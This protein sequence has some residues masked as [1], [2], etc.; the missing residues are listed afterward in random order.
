MDMKTLRFL[1]LP[2]LLAVA[3]VVAGC[4]GGGAKS[5]PQN[6]VAVVGADTITKAQYNALIDSARSTYKAKKTAFPKVGTSAYKSLSDQA[7]TY[8]VQESELEQKGREIGVVVTPKDVDKRIQQIKTQYFQGSQRKYEAALKQQGLTEPQ[9]RRD[10]YAEILSEKLYAKVTSNV[11]VTDADVKKYYQQHISSYTTPESRTVR[12]ILVSSKS[13]ALKLEAQLKK[14]ASFAALAKK[15]SKDTQSA[16]VGGKLTISKGQ[17]VKPFEDSSFSLKTN[18]ISPPVHSQYGWHIIQ[19]LGPVIPAKV[20]PLKTV[21]A[22]IKTSLL[23]SKK[24]EV[25]QKWVDD[26]K[27]QFAS[28]V[29]YQTGYAPAT[30]STAAA[31]TTTAP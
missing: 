10:L 14:G 13:L 23:S 28:K 24:T 26:L 4:G 16:K 27:K 6:A 3:L 18:Q 9:L 8:L 1:P 20:T 22:S 7:M 5:V 25:M 29:S 12:H 15:Y 30:T 17:T 19:A 31:A 11:K 2:L 21:A